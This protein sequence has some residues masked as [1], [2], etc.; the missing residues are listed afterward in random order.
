VAWVKVNIEAEDEPRYERKPL[1]KGLTPGTRSF[2]CKK[3]D[4]GDRATVL[5]A[6]APV[7]FVF[8][9]ISIPDSAPE[10]GEIACYLHD[11][12]MW[13]GKMPC[14]LN[15]FS[16]QFVYF[17]REWTLIAVLRPP[18]WTWPVNCWNT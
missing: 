12:N 2:G 1:N 6:L 17:S 15:S 13:T 16:T 10:N 5:A 14:V 9:P 8:S 7:G 11:S 18:T 3:G 4:E